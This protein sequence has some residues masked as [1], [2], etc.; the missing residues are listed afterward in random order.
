MKCCVIIPVGPGHQELAKRAASSVEEAIEHGK[1]S[2]DEIQIIE[3]D[4]TEGKLGRSHARNL[5][6]QQAGLEHGA[7][8]LFF[9]DADDLMTPT[10][11]LSV[12]GL[13]EE[14]DAI[15]GEIYVADLATQQ[16]HR[17]PNQIT[18]LTSLEQVL[19]ND[20]YFT[21]QMGHFVR[22]AVAEQ[23]PFDT[24]LDCGEDFDYY[25]R[26]WKEKRCI[27]IDQPIFLN[28][29]GQHSSGP[30]SATGHDW[31]LAIN[32]IFQKFCQEN[33]VIASVPC[34]NQQIKF[35]LSN[36]LDTIQNRLAREEFF[37]IKEL[38][39]CAL[40]LPQN[41]RVLDIGS[42]IGNHAL[43]F[44][45]ICKAAEIHCFEPAQ[46][47][48]E[49]L[50]ENFRINEIPPE[51]YK[52]R[53]M[54]LGSRAG[55]ASLDRIDVSNLGATS[56][57][58]DA[59]GSIEIDSLDNLYPEQM[60]DL[61]KIDVEGMELEVLAGGQ[62]LIKRCRPIILIEI[63]NSNKGH[64]FVWAGKNS[65]RVHRTFELVHASNYLLVPQTPRR[66]FY[67]E[68]LVGAREWKPKIALA[69]DQP[70]I[71]WST[72]DF[73]RGYLENRRAIELHLVDS[74]YVA[75]DIKNNSRHLLGNDP[76]ELARKFPGS[77]VLLGDILGALSDGKLHQLLDSCAKTAQELVLF[78]IMDAR[79]DKAFN[80]RRQ[81]RDVEQYLQQTSTRGY[82]L[83]HYQK[84]PHKSAYGVHEQLDNQVTLLHLKKGT[85][86]T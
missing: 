47:I 32:Q 55:K 58:D 56:L 15:W 57:K 8:W 25:L 48:A 4:D 9:L 40:R 61:L 86:T 51:R 50:E 5:A 19:I 30:R 72:S 2:F 49:Q 81:Y 11:F 75:L 54:G 24:S 73:L 36:T 63:A 10:A 28:V 44:T 68:G 21:L 6:I 37:E 52:I 1:G 65:Y 20:P 39:E 43:F 85:K 18:P 41:P 7:D 34:D 83:V 78:D 45:C 70:A 14:Y 35:R 46:H 66:D 80:T 38:S 42:N 71:G 27:K 79:W 33:E 3:L 60:F 53:R 76:S 82:Q 26:V 29:R 23:F 84:L 59:T 22:Q 62:E 31:R 12:A 64:F 67:K 69:P 13:L 74:Q 16:A 77:I 17:R